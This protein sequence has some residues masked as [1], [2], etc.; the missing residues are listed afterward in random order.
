M[1]RIGI[2]VIS[3]N[4]REKVDTICPENIRK[5]SKTY[6][7]NV[8]KTFRNIF[9]KYLEN[10][11][12]MFGKDSENNRK[13]LFLAGWCVPQALEDFDFFDFN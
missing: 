6:S 4:Q 5:M 9:R 3:G 13:M 2:R 12:K 8:R 11:R 10:V 7:E 1:V